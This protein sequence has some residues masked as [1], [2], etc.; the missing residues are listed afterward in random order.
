MYLDRD[1]GC[2]RCRPFE[3]REFVS[4]RV[5]LKVDMVFA[6]L[7]SELYAKGLFV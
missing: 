1:K 4:V 3:G 7:T 2:S 5:L 6:A